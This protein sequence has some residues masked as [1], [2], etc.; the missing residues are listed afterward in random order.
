MLFAV[1]TLK[2]L[3]NGNCF[4]QYHF[5]LGTWPLPLRINAPGE[6]SFHS[7]ELM[8]LLKYMSTPD[9]WALAKCKFPLERPGL[10]LRF[11]I[12]DRLP[13]EPQQ[14]GALGLLV[15]PPILGTGRCFRRKG[16][17]NPPDGMQSERRRSVPSLKAKAWSWQAGLVE[18][19]T[20]KTDSLSSIPRTHTKVEGE[21]QRTWCHVCVH[22]CTH[23]LLC[24][25][26]NH[27]M[28]ALT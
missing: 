4:L 25:R 12:S 22:A 18:A 3:L 19:L 17:A 14:Q 13:R 27:D 15:L 6:G 8:Q 1:I 24:A 20:T 2:K 10:G 7:S 21:N 11:C 28:C 23:I 16:T 5:T 9:T 26:M